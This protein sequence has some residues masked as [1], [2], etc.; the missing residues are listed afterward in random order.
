MVLGT[1]ATE[2]LLIIILMG[3]LLTNIDTVKNLV[4]EDK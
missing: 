3:M 4:G 1:E 2:Y